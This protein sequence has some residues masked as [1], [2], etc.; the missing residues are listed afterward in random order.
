[1]YVR[2]VR[3]RYGPEGAAK[4]TEL[5]DDLVPAIEQQPGCRGAIC[6]GDASDGEYG[7]LVLWDSE[8]SANDAREVIGPRMSKHFEGNLQGDTDIRLFEVLRASSATVPS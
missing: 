2:L 6:F 5:A 4:A 1:M 8:K 7:L 3:F